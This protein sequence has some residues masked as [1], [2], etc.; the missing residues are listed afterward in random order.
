MK[1]T[2]KWPVVIIAFLFTFSLIYGANYW[3]QQNLVMEPLLEQLLSLDGVEDVQVE[4]GRENEIS[5][6]VKKVPHFASLY[7][8]I[9]QVLLSRNEEESRLVIVDNRNGYLDSLYQKIHFALMEGERKGNYTAM[10]SEIEKLLA[11]EEGLDNYALSVDQ[12][13]IYLQFESGNYYLYE[14][15]PINFP[16]ELHSKF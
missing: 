9:Q 2:M 4:R 1:F 16:V 11:G 7:R 3:R 15:V 12:D 8:E 14:V 10:N 6:Y 5:I 13:R